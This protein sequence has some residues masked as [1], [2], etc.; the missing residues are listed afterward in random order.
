[1]DRWELNVGD[2]LTS[3]IEQSLTNSGAIIVIISKNSVNSDWCRREL[4]AGLVRELEEKRTI[5]LPCVIDDCDIPL[6]LR[7]KLYA[8]FRKNPDQA[9]ALVDRALRQVSNPTMGRIENPE[10]HTDYSVDWKPINDAQTEETWAVRWTFIDHSEK[11]PYAVLSEMKIYVVTGEDIYAEYLRKKEGLAFV[12]RATTY[13]ANKFLENPERGLIEDNNAKFVAWR[14]E[15]SKAEE[16][17]TIYSYR[18]MGVDNGFDVAVH[19]D[20]NIRKALQYFDERTATPS[21]PG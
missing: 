11:L 20:D 9:F 17:L 8:D 1:M 4:N 3:M 14:T 12:K 18:K 19:L 15:I 13:V 21:H 2:S 10:F 7:D 16:Y 6:F 5:V